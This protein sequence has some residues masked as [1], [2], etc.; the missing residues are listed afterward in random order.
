MCGACCEFVKLSPE[1]IRQIYGT[2]VDDQS[3]IVGSLS[4]VFES[5]PKS[6][7]ITEAEMDDMRYNVLTLQRVSVPENYFDIW[8]P[9]GMLWE[10]V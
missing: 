5:L 6:K 8:T 2:E 3:D 1:M 9:R 10:R 4:H 7:D